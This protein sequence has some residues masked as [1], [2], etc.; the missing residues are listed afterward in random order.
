MKI[1]VNVQTN[2]D[3][4]QSSNDKHNY[5]DRR[6]YNNLPLHEGEYLVPIRVD[7]DMVRHFNMDRNNLETW[8]VG[9]HKVLVAFAPVPVEDKVAAIKHF[10]R[11]VREFYESFRTEDV[12]SLDQFLEDAAADGS[13][14]FEPASDENLE[15]NVMLRII[16]EDLF[17]QVREINPRYGQILDMLADDYSKGEIVDALKLRKSQ[18][19]DEIKAA[20]ALARKLYYGE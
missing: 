16:I 6:S 2:A 14:G 19:Y 5:D 4:Q 10:N 7:W 8:R 9:P 1:T 18:G 11:D 13:K 20:Q 3:N 12:L 17:K 15:E